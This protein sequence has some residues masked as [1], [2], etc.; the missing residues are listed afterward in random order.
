MNV[1]A[2]VNLDEQNLLRAGALYQSYTLDDWWP[3][4]GAMMWPGTFDNINDGTRDR[5][6]L[7]GEWES[8]INTQWLTL[9]GARYERVKT[10]AG[11]VRGYDQNTNGMGMMVNNQNNDAAAFNAQDRERTDNN[12]ELTA[13]A[14]PLRALYLVD[15]GRHEK[16]GR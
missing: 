8:R 14:Q 1:E 7:F 15:G 12:R 13:L 10:D 9:L 6:G 4:S 11:N 3:P 5:L 2:E 16:L